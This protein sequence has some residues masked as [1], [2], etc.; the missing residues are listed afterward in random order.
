MSQTRSDQQMATIVTRATKDLHRDIAKKWG[1]PANVIAGST[2]SLAVT[3]MH[4]S[5]YTDDQIV[6]FA[7]QLLAE[8]GAPPESRGAA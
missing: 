7:R 1:F 6:E 5:G 3:M 8:L 2:F 4:D